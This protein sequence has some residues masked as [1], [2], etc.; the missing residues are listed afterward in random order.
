ML[1][2]LIQLLV[3]LGSFHLSN[4][5]A[6]SVKITNIMADNDDSSITGTAS[7][8]NEDNLCI[9]THS[10]QSG[11]RMVYPCQFCSK[12]FSEISCLQRHI[13]IHTGEK[14]YV[15][16]TCQKQFKRKDHLKLHL[17]IH[18]GEKP[19]KCYQCDY[20][21]NQS[22]NLKS[23]MISKHSNVAKFL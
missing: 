23:H 17:R 9:L 11:D 20:R 13:R 8:L 15:C 21:S 5:P 2:I 10:E 12:V 16:A 19:Y 14:P 3:F 4:F 7:N 6:M 22:C 1:L 18:T